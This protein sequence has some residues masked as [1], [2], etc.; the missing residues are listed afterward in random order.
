MQTILEVLA[1]AFHLTMHFDAGLIEIVLLSLRVSLTAVA[2]AA[3]IGPPLGAAIALSRFPG[4][5]FAAILL[6]SLMGLPPVG[7]VASAGKIFRDSAATRACAPSSGATPAGPS[8]TACMV[9]I[10][11]TPVVPLA[12]G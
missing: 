12:R 2:L 4:R 1:F 3:V 11:P 6:N 7:A 5:R 10:A 8:G 9:E